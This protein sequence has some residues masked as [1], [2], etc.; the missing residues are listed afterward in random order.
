VGLR[1]RLERARG[2]IAPPKDVAP[3]E[4]PVVMPTAWRRDHPATGALM[5]RSL[6]NSGFGLRDPETSEALRR[7][8]PALLQ[9][10]VLVVPLHEIAERRDDQ[11]LLASEPG[12]ALRL[13]RE[14]G[15][16]V[17]YDREGQLDIG[18][19]DEDTSQSVSAAID[20]GTELRALSLWE[21]T[22]LNQ[23]RTGLDI[24]IA[25]TRVEVIIE[26]TG[27]SVFAE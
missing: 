24:L 17:V 20:D 27:R 4:A 15:R 13:V 2:E 22:A 19:L 14:G 16:I 11:R 1:E 3:D 7:D 21:T 26:A 12:T 25:P 9:L 5:L 8:D 10:G 23:M 6:G 18:E